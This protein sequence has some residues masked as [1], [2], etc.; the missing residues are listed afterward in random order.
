M[1][2]VKD[3]QF[4]S[5]LTAMLDMSGHGGNPDQKCMAGGAYSGELR[6]LRSRALP[7]FR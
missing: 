7:E 2:Q 3:Y 4:T 5:K 1:A 6:Y